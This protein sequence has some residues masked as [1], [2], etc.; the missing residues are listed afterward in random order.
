MTPA[1]TYSYLQYIVLLFR[2][3][4]MGRSQA[5]V[6]PLEYQIV[7]FRERARADV[8]SFFFPFF[9][10]EISQRVSSPGL[11]PLSR[12]KSTGLRHSLFKIS[13]DA[14]S[15]RSYLLRKAS[16]TSSSRQVSSRRPQLEKLTCHQLS[17]YRWHGA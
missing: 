4:H 14:L 13:L 11:R 1:Q 5:I 15:F 12:Y 8:S 3:R 6:S 17:L 10:R 9:S 7:S 2:S 16:K